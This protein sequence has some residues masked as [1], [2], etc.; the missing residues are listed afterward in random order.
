MCLREECYLVE[1]GYGF[2]SNGEKGFSRGNYIPYRTISNFIRSRNSYSVFCSA[3]RYNNQSV[4]KSDLYGDLYL[5]FDDTNNFEHVRKDALTA[6]SY[7]KIVYHIDETQVQIY[8]SGN[9]GVHII[10]PAKIFGFEPMPLLNGVFKT[11]ALSIRSFTP[12]KTIDTQ[13]YDNKRMFRIP[14]TIHEKSNLYKIP[15]TPDELRKLSETEIRTMAQ[16]PRQLNTRPVIETNHIAE[17]QFQKAI[18]EFY[19]LDKES[20]KDRRFKSKYNFTPPCIQYLLTNGAP[21]GQRN[22][23]IACLTGF[24]KNSGKSLNETIELISDWNQNNVKPTGEQEMKKTI[25]SIFG[26]EKIFGCTTLK[27]ISVCNEQQCKFIK[28]KEGQNNADT[29]KSNKNQT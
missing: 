5:D 12:N 16:Q 6:L 29:S 9:K 2:N 13:I 7:L 28:K 15:I 4:D 1:V 23:S 24:Y 26:G 25:K 17:Q 19:I 18:E 27:L 22:V 14:N 21:E 11:I 3:Y 8:F 20:K 10:V